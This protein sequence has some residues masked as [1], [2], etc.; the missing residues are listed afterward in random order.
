MRPWFSAAIC[1]SAIYILS[2]AGLSFANNGHIIQTYNAGIAAQN[3]HDSAQAETLFRKALQEA[4]STHDP[5]IGTI[6]NAL[7]GIYF[8]RKTF[9]EA[10]H[11]YEMAFAW[12]NK[13]PAQNM[14]L[15]GNILNNLGAIYHQEK[16][17]DKAK[18]YYNQA[19]AILQKTGP[20]GAA[21]LQTAMKNLSELNRY[22]TEN[23]PQTKSIYER[24]R[25]AL[26]S[27][28]YEEAESLLQ[29]AL[30]NAPPSDANYG[31]ILDALGKVA[32]LKHH[33][34]EAAGYLEKALSVNEK[35]FGADSP[36]LTT[37]LT[38]LAEVSFAQNKIVETQNLCNRA[39][40]IQ[41]H[42]RNPDEGNIRH[43]KKI[44]SHIQEIDDKPDYMAEQLKETTRWSD[45]TKAIVVYTGAGERL[46]S[47][48]PE[49]T[50][51]VKQAFQEWQ[52]AI[53]NRLVF[54]FSDRPDQSDVK[55]V[56]FEKPLSN[57]NNDD[58]ELHV[59]GQCNDQV[60]NHY[61]RQSNL[62]LSLTYKSGLPINPHE[63]HAIALHEIGHLLGIKGHSKN[64]VDIMYWESTAN[65][66]ISARDIAT[67]KGI[68]NQPAVNTNP[69]GIHLNEFNQ[70]AAMADAG[71]EAFNQKDYRQS[72]DIL[73]NALSLYPNDDKTLYWMGL[74]AL[75]MKDYTDATQWFGRIHNPKFE[76][77]AQLN[78]YMG[79]ALE[80]EARQEQNKSGQITTEAEAKYTQA[81]N[82]LKLAMADPM[83]PAQDKLNV[84]EHI[85]QVEKRH[86]PAIVQVNTISM[87][88][89]D[90]VIIWAN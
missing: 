50:E 81:L 15:K 27:E 76:S 65:D 12:F 35:K 39:I 64:P 57:T 86:D 21:T 71:A 49:Y 48:K 13:Q 8:Q 46:P 28:Q 60:W 73:K 36:N 45:H 47:W 53:D 82:Y 22:L 9:P 6:A 67:F 10:K 32:N 16:Q 59:M 87:P 34:D 30:K 75:N 51:L 17:W 55:I 89:T 29:E 68:Y 61:I 3:N 52:Q 84:S 33:Y 38:A 56:W 18:S 41:S 66:K 31:N 26:Q 11:Y 23:N 4:E 90:D 70:F 54:Q 74:S 69:N 63:L 40:A 5:N 42:Q 20:Q 72:Y 2:T 19:I 79:Y 37:T 77:Q 7:A 80:G 83:L 24:G 43:L 44:L 1:L 62:N 78:A 25:S 85:A 88:K 58:G 14:V